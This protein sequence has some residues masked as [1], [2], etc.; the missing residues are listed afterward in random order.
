MSEV[1]EGGNEDGSQVPSIQESNSVSEGIVDFRT[2][3]LK[4]LKV[5]PCVVIV[6]VIYTYLYANGVFAPTSKV[7]FRTLHTRSFLLI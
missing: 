7:H 2:I 3:Y 5:R 6:V 1:W 4:V